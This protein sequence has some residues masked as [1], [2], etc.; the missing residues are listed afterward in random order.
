[1]KLH[2]LFLVTL[3]AAALALAGCGGDDDDDGGSGGTGSGGG[4]NHGLAGTEITA[5]NAGQVYATVMSGALQV[6]GKGAGTHNGANSGTV[7]ITQSIGKPV[8]TIRYTCEYDDYSDDGQTF[9]NGTIRINMSGT[10]Y[11]YTFDLDVSGV[12]SGSIE[13]EINMANGVYSGYWN[14]NGTR[15]NFPM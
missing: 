7:K 11:S 4:D 9:L 1:M 12:Y 6:M 3:S 13:G 10:S 5:A 15:I 14:V 2:R 8:Q